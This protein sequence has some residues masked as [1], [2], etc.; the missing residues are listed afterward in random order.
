M[1]REDRSTFDLV[2]GEPCRHP[3]KWHVQV[4][5]PRDLPCP[6]QLLRSVEAIAR[7]RVDL[8]RREQSEL[9]VMA[10]RVNR[11][12]GQPR[13][14]PDGESLLAHGAESAVSGYPRVKRPVSAHGRG[15]AEAP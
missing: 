8:G 4:A 6:F 15:G 7:L 5:Q 3:G 14:P 2:R 11:Q 10:E 13:E 12:P 9:V 1:A